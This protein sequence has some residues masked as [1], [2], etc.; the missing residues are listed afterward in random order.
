MEAISKEILEER[1]KRFLEIETD[2]ENLGYQYWLSLTQE[3]ATKERFE[4]RQVEGLASGE[5]KGSNAEQR[6]GSAQQVYSREWKAYLYAR[7]EVLKLKPDFQ[8]LEARFQIQ[9]ALLRTE[10]ALIRIS[11]GESEE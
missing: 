5:V 2:Y 11:T 7:G 8:L 9:K 10:E 1:R 6:Q 3:A 4:N